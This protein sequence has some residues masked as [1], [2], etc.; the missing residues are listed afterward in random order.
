MRQLTR[1]LFTTLTAAGL[2]QAINYAPINKKNME[3]TMVKTDEE[4][5]SELNAQ[6]I[7]NFINQDTV[8]HNDIIHKDFVCI[9][10]SGAVIDRDTYMKDWSHG[11]ETSKYTSFSY[12]D[13]SIR[14]FG[15]MALVRSKTV[16]TKL[17][18]GETV[19][20]N[21]VYTDTY[22]RENGRWWCVQAQLTPVR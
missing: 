16:Y 18:D 6:F 3:Q 11:Y 10:S 22:I 15:N 1:L 14:V 4:V 21:T 19:H 8:S 2:T 17:I 20:G 9:Y 12:T 5:L 13:E 7:K